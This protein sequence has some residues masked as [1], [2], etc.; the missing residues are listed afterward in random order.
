[1]HTDSDPTATMTT[2]IVIEITRALEPVSRDTFIDG[3][4]APATRLDRQLYAASI[5]RPAA[6]GTRRTKDRLEIARAIP[7]R[8]VIGLGRSVAH[9]RAA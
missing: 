3:A 5:L 4:D 2:P 9:T 1:M 7:R 8:A 6:V